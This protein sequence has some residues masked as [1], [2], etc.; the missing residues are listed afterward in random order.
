[1]LNEK[2]IKTFHLEK[3]EEAQTHFAKARKLMKMWRCE[4]NNEKF[5]REFYIG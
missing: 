5:L 2:P 3:D 1:M 4:K